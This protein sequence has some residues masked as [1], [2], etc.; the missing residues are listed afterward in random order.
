M[1]NPLIIG[2]A[3]GSGSGKTT[4]VNTI[5]KTL[6]A[7]KHLLLQHDSYYRD[8]KHLPFEERIKQNFDHPASLE[9]ELLIRHINALSEGYPIEVPQYDFAKHIRKEQT[10]SVTPK[11]VI[12]VDGILIFSEPELLELMDV[13]IF[14]DTDDDIR[15]LRRLKRDISERGRS[16]E[17]VMEQYQKFVRPMHLEFVQPSK[18]YADVIIPRGGKNKVAL[19]MVLALINEKLSNRE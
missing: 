15:L 2:V 10:T 18:R 14:V 13:K 3:G 1:T 5:S 4:V 8:L 6:G 11:E 7:N 12:L 16:V 17:N 9:T 19:D